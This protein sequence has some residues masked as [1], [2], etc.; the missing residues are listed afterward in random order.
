ME[1]FF[2][3]RIKEEMKK[4]MWLSSRKGEKADVMRTE[5]NWEKK[6]EKYEGRTERIKEGTY[7]TKHESKGKTM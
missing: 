5:K 4:G 1:L 6:E 7:N 2:C 3:E